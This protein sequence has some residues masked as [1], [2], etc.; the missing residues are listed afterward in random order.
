MKI[1]TQL[2]T[3]PLSKKLGQQI[4]NLDRI[5]ILELDKQEII[6]L[7]KSYGVLLFR[8]FESNLETFTQFSNSLSTNFR[9]YTGGV[10][11]RKIINGNSTILTVN[12]FKDEIKLHGEMY[13]QQNIPEMLW[14]F[15]RSA[16]LTRWRNNSM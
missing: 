9:D 14:F 12:D 10:F 6:K 8:G 11:N 15:L 4:I 1:N 5:S 2:H 13:Y 16:S 7:F 3:R